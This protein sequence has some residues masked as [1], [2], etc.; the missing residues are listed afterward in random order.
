MGCRDHRAGAGPAH[1]LEESSDG[2]RNAG[3]VRFKPL[4]KDH[5]EVHLLLVYETHGAVESHGQRTR[6]GRRQAR[7]KIR[8]VEFK[9]YAERHAFRNRGM[10]R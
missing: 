4:G 6:A 7:D 10:A 2:A 9:D 5:T 3:T 1:L 8:C